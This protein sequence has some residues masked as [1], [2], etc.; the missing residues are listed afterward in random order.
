M[1]CDYFEAERCRSCTLMGTAYREQVT[2]KQD[3]AREALAAVGAFPAWSEPFE[4]RESG[5]RNK[6][7]LVVAGSVDS[8]ALGI[9]DSFGRGI[10]LR[11]CGLYDPRLYAV[12]ATLAA[13][14][15]SA[16]LTP[17]DVPSRRGELKY[18]IVTVSPGGQVMVRFVLRSQH[19]VPQ[20]NKALPQLF[21]SISDLAVVSVN[22]HP[23]HKAVLEG[24]TEI[25]LSGRH[26]LPM[27]VNDVV[28]QLRPKSFFQTNTEVA[29]GLYR[30][31]HAWIDELDP[32]SV[33]D[34]YCGVGGFA[35]HA[36]RSPRASVRPRSVLGIE[37]FAEAIDSARESL[38]A[39]HGDDPRTSQVRF[40]A[41]DATAYAMGRSGP[42]L[43][44]VNPPR[45]GIG[46]ELTA[47]LERS[48]TRHLVYSSC[49]PDSLARDL[50]A[51]PSFKVTDARVFDMF[52]QTSHQE[53]LIRATRR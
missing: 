36:V 30:Q 3:R 33:W 5:F 8:P 15:T 29:A 17:Y 40:E 52:P 51:L 48:A 27:Q 6:A 39:M 12:F 38:A 22:L 20:I 9:L 21:S 31:A 42:E 32:A 10:D 34:L 50:A 44:I 46:P 14:V 2:A 47:W 1:R 24:D 11:S 18:L 25:I 16:G 53:V 26:T 41:A 4:S 28:L 7:K 35:L 13:L 49:N 19:L 43:V 37:I 45:R 23:E